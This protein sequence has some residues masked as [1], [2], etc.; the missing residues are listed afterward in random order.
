LENVEP[1]AEEIKKRVSSVTVYGS[2]HKLRRITQLI[3]PERD[4]AWLKEIERE[5]FSQMRPRSKWDR[6]VLA[7]VII[8]AGL[9]LIAEAELAVKLPKLT[10]ARMVRNGLMLTLLAQC[11]IRLKNFAALKIG[12][13]IVK[14]DN[15]WWILLTA[16]E[17]KEKRVDER[18]IDHDIGD[19]I[20]NYLK[21]YRPIL[22]RGGDDTNAL[23]LA[24]NGEAMAQCS[25]A[26]VIAET[27]R[28][29][30]GVAISPHLFRTA[31]ATTAAI[32]AGDKPHLGTALLHHSHPVVTLEN[33][34]RASSIS[35]GR[36]YREVNQRLR[37]KKT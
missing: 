12:G 25:V 17:T 16:S 3:A 35:A 34:N 22:A 4:L 26:E 36:A 33:Y 8:E 37:S 18:P 5:L 20:D 29:T 6:V 7:E 11:P 14:I 15:T 24:I 27:T 2:I 30:I 19:A 21:F 32:H 1:Y 28:S 10:R 23:W 13:S 31:A 9:T